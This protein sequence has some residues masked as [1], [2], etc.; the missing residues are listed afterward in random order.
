M[1]G[2]TTALGLSAPASGAIEP[3]PCEYPAA[4]RVVA[5]GHL[6]GETEPFLE[7]LRDAG[8]ADDAGRWIGGDAR[9]VILGNFTGG[10]DHILDLVD[11]IRSLEDQARAAGG[12]VHALLGFYE[13]QLLRGDF[14]FVSQDNYA[15]LAT[16]GSD[17]RRRERIEATVEHVIEMLPPM[18]E[19]TEAYQRKK[20]RNLMDLRM[21]LGGV[22][23]ADLFAPG[24]ERGDWLR[25]RNSVIKIGDALY[26]RGGLGPQY[27]EL[28]LTEVNDLVRRAVRTET[29]FP[30]LYQIDLKLPP[31][32]SSLPTRPELEMREGYLRAL[33]QRD[34]RVQ[35]V[36]VNTKFDTVTRW[37]FGGRA[38]YIDSGIAARVT[39]FPNRTL[40]YV[41]VVGG[42]YYLVMGG[43]RIA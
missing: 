31:Y 8:L 4:E 11:L 25:S 26:S 40:D 29:M 34:V 30:A 13:I 22:E 20:F 39:G 17:Q 18:P 2:L 27:G 1:I 42:R 23:F 36:G 3:P 10:G 38:I 12:A 41:D 6:A 5:V 14:E 16:E 15:H 37:G 24:T 35:V 21:G 9:L 43:R 7:I 28:T 19:Q 33:E 32:W